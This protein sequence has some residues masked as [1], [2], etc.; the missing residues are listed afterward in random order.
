MATVKKKRSHHAKASTKHAQMLHQQQLEAQLLKQKQLRDNEVN[1]LKPEQVSAVIH[2]ES[3]TISFRANLLKNFVVAADHM[4][5]LTA[6]AVPLAQIR[7]PRVF[8][9]SNPRTLATIATAFEDKVKQEQALLDNLKQAAHI[10]GHSTAAPAIDVDVPLDSMAKVDSVA[11]EYIAKHGLRMQDRRVVIH[12]GKFTHLKSDTREA[13]ADYWTTTHKELLREHKRQEKIKREEEERKKQEEETR[14][15]RE[16]E[17][18]KLEEQRKLQELEQ[19]RLK[20]QQEEEQR[21]RQQELQQQQQQQ[22]QQQL[23]QQQQQQHQGEP[24][25]GIVPGPNATP[26]IAAEPVIRQG[27]Q[28][29]PPDMPVQ[30]Q[31]ITAN[32]GIVPNGLTESNELPS[33]VDSTSAD[34]SQTA[35]VDPNQQEN[36]LDDMFTEYN[37]NNNEPFSNSFDDEFGD[38]FDNLDN[39]FF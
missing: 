39:V 12:R 5:L 2:D 4:A 16:E 19:Q 36:L 10:A 7:P 29:N 23:Q 35:N 22:Q 9:S 31:P 27:S 20:Q 24:Q 11:A 34:P 30:P 28:S 6:Q 21:Q 17:E 37:T 32:A 1:R 25:S 18:K 15:L 3:D 8:Q 38:G 14:R 33:V 26:G 13:P